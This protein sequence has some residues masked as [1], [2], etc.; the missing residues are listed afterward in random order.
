MSALADY[1]A[2][3]DRIKAL[4]LRVIECDRLS[5]HD[6]PAALD[7][8]LDQAGLRKGL[9]RLQGLHD[10]LW[11]L[12]GS[13]SLRRALYPADRCMTHD[14]LYN[15]ISNIP[16][17]LH[18]TQDEVVARI[19]DDLD[20]ASIITP[21]AGAANQDAWIDQV[22]Q[23][24]GWIEP[25][26]DG[27]CPKGPCNPREGSDLGSPFSVVIPFTSENYWPPVDWPY[28]IHTGSQ[29]AALDQIYT[30]SAVEYREWIYPDP[31]QQGAETLT[32]FGQLA[33][34]IN[35][36]ATRG[37]GGTGPRWRSVGSSEYPHAVIDGVNYYSSPSNWDQT[38]DISTGFAN[39]LYR[40]SALDTDSFF[41]RVLRKLDPLISP[42]G[43]FRQ[44]SRG[45]ESGYNSI[46]DK[47]GWSWRRETLA[48]LSTFTS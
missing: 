11:A 40:I 13:D 30:L 42:Q 25:L 39:G 23:V 48:T 19:L 24:L 26:Y 38:W 5:S 8:P 1:V 31:D 10:A 37:I 29:Q 16:L 12:T 34:P 41:T 35:L 17:Q 43:N 32:T 22:D 15:A 47:T 3:R 18:I 27:K 36:T 9:A 46:L 33:S 45:N 4:W 6:Y 7:F 44:E 28:A 21:Q 20:M 14:Q 2:I